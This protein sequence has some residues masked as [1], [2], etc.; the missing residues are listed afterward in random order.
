[1]R[2]E[3]FAADSELERS[4]K[5]EL[6]SHFKK[7]SW[8]IRLSKHLLEPGLAACMTAVGIL[9]TALLMLSSAGLMHAGS[10]RSCGLSPS[11]CF[12]SLSVKHHSC[13]LMNPT[14]NAN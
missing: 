14:S 6:C 3:R 2:E 13:F 4:W 9:H 5:A 11:R 10:G 7:S 8:K 1:M 12:W